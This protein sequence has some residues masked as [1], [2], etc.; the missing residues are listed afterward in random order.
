M[1]NDLVN[2]NVLGGKG[3]SEVETLLGAPNYS[4]SGWYGYAIMT[5]SK[6]RVW[7]CRVNVVFDAETQKVVDAAVDE[8]LVH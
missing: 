4:A 2:R 8:H 1:A 7:T 6:C 3:A 5:S